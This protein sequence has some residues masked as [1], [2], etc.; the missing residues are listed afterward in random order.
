MESLIVP[1]LC[2]IKSKFIR[3]SLGVST[4]K[5]LGGIKVSKTLSLS[6][7]R[8]ESKEIVSMSRDS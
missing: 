1:C 6:T 3:L 2:P 7:E 8:E 4:G 5:T